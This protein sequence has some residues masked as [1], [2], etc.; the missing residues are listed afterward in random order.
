[1]KRIASFFAILILPCIGPACG[2][3]IWFGPH[4]PGVWYRGPVDWKSFLAPDA[5]WQTVA[6]RVAVLGESTGYFDYAKDDELKQLTANLAA[7]HASLEFGVQAVAKVPGEKCGGM[8][9]YGSPE[10]AVAVAQRM[11]NL[12]VDIPWID[13]DEP[14]WFGHFASNPQACGLPIEEVAHRV[15]RT[16]RGVVAIF[17]NIKIVDIEPVPD[18]TSQPGWQGAFLTYSRVLEADLGKPLSMVGVDVGWPIPAWPYHLAL[19]SEFAK[20]NNL[21]FA[22]IYNGEGFDS[23]DKSWTDHA[24]RNFEQIEG[25][26]GIVPDVAWFASWNIQPEYVLPE[27]EPTSH[28]GLIMSYLKERTHF[29]ASSAGRVLRGRLIDAKGGGIANAAVRLQ[30]PGAQ[31]LSVPEIQQISGKV[32]PNAVSAVFTFGINRPCN[33]PANN[34]V[35]VGDFHY[36]EPGFPADDHVVSLTEVVAGIRDPHAMGIDRAEVFRH[37]GQR[38]ARLTVRADQV[39]SY[40]SPHF[41]V[42]AGRD[43][44]LSGPIGSLSPQDMSGYIDVVWFDAKGKDIWRTPLFVHR[45]VAEAAS[46]TTDHDGNFVFPNTPVALAGV[47]G[48]VYEGNHSL[49]AVAVNVTAH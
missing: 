29:V 34:D 1:M 6:S 39:F 43:F 5:P 31:P 30:I 25:E 45:T 3:D 28:T 13:I 42:H 35:L 2:Q 32:P 10:Q 41:P 19:W 26:M 36:R 48:L 8:E 11:K 15:A 21:K 18:L 40:G 9:G 16:L 14:V 7:H 37:N 46:A 17:P 38:V 20:A 49:R 33:C 22:I 4:A 23:T 47:F 12:G 27:T 24:R 44:T